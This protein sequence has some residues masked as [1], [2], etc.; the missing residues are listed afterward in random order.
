[1]VFTYVAGGFNFTLSETSETMYCKTGANTKTGETYSNKKRN[2]HLNTMNWKFLGCLKLILFVISPKRFVRLHSLLCSYQSVFGILFVRL[3][4]L[5]G[6]WNKFFSY[7]FWTILP[8]TLK[9][10]LVKETK[11]KLNGSSL[12]AILLLSSGSHHEDL[13]QIK[14]TI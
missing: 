12:T 8:K 7:H 2:Q 6:A 13:W 4:N 9:G 3:I 5:T 14:F 10:V 1:M 11:Y